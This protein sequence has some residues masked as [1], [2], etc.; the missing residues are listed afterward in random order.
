MCGNIGLLGKLC[1]SDF[2]IGLDSALIPV[3]LPAESQF[4][5]TD[6]STQL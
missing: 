6:L 2:I 5:G 1:D 4:F 3:M